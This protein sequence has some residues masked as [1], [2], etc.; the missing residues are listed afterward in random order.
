MIQLQNHLRTNLKLENLDEAFVDLQWRIKRYSART[1]MPVRKKTA[2]LSEA[3][4]AYAEK[5]AAYLFEQSIAPRIL[6]VEHIMRNAL[7][8]IADTKEP[9]WD[10][11]YTKRVKKIITNEQH[12]R[13]RR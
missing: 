13:R 1:G 8:K 12:A 5:R 3:R 2:L 7:N 10:V 4:R 9:D 11:L 6:R